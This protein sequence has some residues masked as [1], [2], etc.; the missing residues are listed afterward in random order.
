MF[1]LTFAILGLLLG[2]AEVYDSS[3]AGQLVSSPAELV[4]PEGNTTSSE[5][6]E[7]NTVATDD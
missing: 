3:G 4:M 1:V 2:I 6:A 5:E 7:N